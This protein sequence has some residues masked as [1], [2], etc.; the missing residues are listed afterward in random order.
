MNPPESARFLREQRPELGDQVVNE[1]NH[2]FE[3]WKQRLTLDN[4]RFVER[5]LKGDLNITI[6]FRY[7]QSPS[8]LVACFEGA[9]GR[10]G[11]MNRFLAFIS[12]SASV[13]VYPHSRR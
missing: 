2:L 9:N 5:Y 6:R 13:R 11:R 8:D 4:A 1:I 12:A 10:I 3:R 7:E